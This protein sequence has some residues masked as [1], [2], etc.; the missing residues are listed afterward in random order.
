MAV[1]FNRELGIWELCATGW[2]EVAG[3]TPT[4]ADVW[5][6]RVNLGTAV[7]RPGIWLQ[8]GRHWGFQL[9]LDAERQLMVHRRPGRCRC[10][11]C[12][13]ARTRLR[14]RQKPGWDVTCDL[15]RRPRERTRETTG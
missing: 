12:T 9:W 10:W 14:R 1:S 7:T 8:T 5:T 11:G 2:L 13:G 6:L 4:N 3:T 15:K